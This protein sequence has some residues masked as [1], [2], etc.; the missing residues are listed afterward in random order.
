[1]AKG[2][3]S[4]KKSSM[5]SQQQRLPAK[6]AHDEDDGASS[7]ASSTIPLDLQQ[8]CLN[9]FRDACSDYFEAQNPKTLQEVKGRLFNR[10][11]GTAF[12][13]EEYLQAYAAR[14]SPS[15]AL[16]YLQVFADIA[17]FLRDTQRPAAS[18]AGNDTAKQEEDADVDDKLEDDGLA[19][20]A[21]SESLGVDDELEA[22]GLATLALSKSLDEAAELEPD[23]MAKLSLSKSHDASAE[24][25][26]EQQTVTQ[27]SS[28]PPA[29]EDEEPPP[30]DSSTQ[31]SVES[32]KPKP[33]H[34]VCLGGGAGADLVGVAGWLKLAELEEAEWSRSYTSV[35]CI[36]IADWDSIVRNLHQNLT[37][38]PVL[39][40]YAS[41]AAKESNTAM[42]TSEKLSTLFV[43]QDI[44]DIPSD[45]TDSL[46]NNPNIVTL[47]FTL[48]ELY[49]TSVSKT[50]HL[51]FQLTAVMRPG[52]HLLVVDSP[53]S[54]SNV[55]I[56]GQKHPMSWLLDHTLLKASS[57]TGVFSH[58]KQW[59]KLVEDSS[60]WFRLPQGLKYPMELEDM[61]YQIHL[62][63]RCGKV[64]AGPSGAAGR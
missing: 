22:D 3:A 39:S 53:G 50:Q 26:S 4:K 6:P 44:L 5:S 15:R 32:D 28:D 33:L 16:G 64:T 9:I 35:R 60:K 11:F 38:P 18:A 19:T 58:R 45:M 41:A 43:Q 17:P 54:Y 40:K 34:I 37:S 14:W 47:M 36:D 49:N 62:Y 20:V 48:N 52:A 42:I 24:Q 21:L 59:E 29:Y 7:K 61:R 55:P 23:R 1:M 12:G 46:F 2:G 63:R 27:F 51:L 13:R 30:Y 56:N 31:V 25:E 8:R 57:K 10:D